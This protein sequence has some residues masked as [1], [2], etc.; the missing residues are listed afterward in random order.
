MKYLSKWVTSKVLDQTYK[1]S[2]RPH[3][4]YGDIIFHDK[5][6]NMMDAL[7]R[8]QYQAGLI[9]SKCWRGTN[10]EKL[11]DQLGWE[12]LSDR[13]IFRRFCLY[14][15]IKMGCLLII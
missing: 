11:Y 15:K 13:R 14:Y 5:I 2:V 6:L 4:E 3:L 8:I 1:M 7:E 10:R 12:S 9:V